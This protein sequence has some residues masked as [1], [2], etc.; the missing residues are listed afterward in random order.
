MISV[1]NCDQG[2]TLIE[3]L[4]AIVVLTI[5]ILA[6]YSMQIA[7]VKGNATASRLT[8][9]S[10]LAADRVERILVLDYE[11]DVVDEDNDGTNQDGNSDGIDDDGGNYGLD[12]MACCWDVAGNNFDPAGNVVAGCVERAD[13]C[14]SADDYWI[15][16]NIA[17]E[18]AMPNTKSIRILVRRLSEP[19]KP[20]VVVNHLKNKFF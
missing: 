1:R 18:V 5:G 8:S 9:A 4:V 13:Q 17:E 20:P 2:F 19:N 14:F 6:V 12:D 11:D 10:S 3:A 15:F 7:S 16:V